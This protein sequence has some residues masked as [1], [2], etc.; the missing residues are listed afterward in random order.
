MM[1]LTCDGLV[2]VV[3]CFGIG[4]NVDE[5]ELLACGVELSSPLGRGRGR[6]FADD[7]LLA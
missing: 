1:E 6:R 5:L 4:S 7:A 3:D 2:R